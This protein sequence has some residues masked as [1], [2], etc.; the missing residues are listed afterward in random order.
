MEKIHK[1]SG[2][3]FAI[4]AHGGVSMQAPFNT[5]PAFAVALGLGCDLELDVHMT[6]DE[7]IVVIHDKTVDHTT[8]GTGKTAEKALAE[9][10]RLDA[11]SWFNPA[12][13][14]VRIPTLEEVLRLIG[15][16]GRTHITVAINM[17]TPLSTG[18]ERKIVHIVEKYGMVDQV[19]A[20]DMPFVSAKRF[21]AANPNFPTAALAEDDAI[22][23]DDTAFDRRPEALEAVLSLPYIDC[24]WASEIKRRWITSKVV[25][26]VHNARK[27]IYATWMCIR[28]PSE[29][30]RLIEAGVDGMCVN[31]ALRLRELLHSKYSAYDKQ[32]KW[33]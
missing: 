18:I 11:G 28:N 15:E 26:E 23:I 27:K 8:D 7:N 6:K 1:I 16:L 24:I 29:W 32:R 12:F 19:F 9:I 5:L 33:T 25:A 17:K 2:S 20:F 22:V 4:L 30:K 13:A 21:K 10:K 14:G 31:D 3:S